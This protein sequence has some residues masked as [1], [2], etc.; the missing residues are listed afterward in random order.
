MQGQ[1]L[2]CVCVWCVRVLSARR[3]T[4][5]VWVIYGVGVEWVWGMSMLCVCVWVYAVYVC[6]V[7]CMSNMYRFRM[8]LCYVW[9]VCRGVW[10]RVCV[11]V[12]YLQY[13]WLMWYVCCAGQHVWCMWVVHDMYVVCCVCTL[14]VACLWVGVVL[15][16]GAWCV[17]AYGACAS[18]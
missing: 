12:L 9:Y 15:P 5:Y 13:V 14:C 2:E 11:P 1:W 4:V 8:H 17:R 3:C 7:A 18:M 6:G 16:V 10:C